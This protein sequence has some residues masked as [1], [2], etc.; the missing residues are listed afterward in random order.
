MVRKNAKRLL[1]KNAPREINNG[2][3]GTSARLGRHLFLLCLYYKSTE[4]P[5][6][7]MAYVFTSYGE[8]I[9]KF[10]IL[11]IKLEHITDPNK[12]MHIL[13]DRAALTPTVNALKEKEKEK[14][15]EKARGILE[16]MQA[17]KTVNQALWC[18]EDRIRLKERLTQFDE[19]FIALARSVYAQN[20]ER[21]RI[22]RELN[23]L[24][25]SPLVEEK[26]YSGGGG[27]GKCA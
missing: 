1:L 18:V 5:A 21:A 9:D 20:D 24:T 11:E 25:N 19:E 23:V 17:L 26:S 15:K 2:K 7:S 14:E 13:R 27:G 3:K 22:K 4:A 10:T 8:I 12:R 16:L 6:A